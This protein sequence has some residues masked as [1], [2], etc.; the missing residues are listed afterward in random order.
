MN[1]TCVCTFHICFGKC[2]QKLKNLQLTF[3]TDKQSLKVKGYRAAG[4][5]NFDGT[6][7]VVNCAS[8]SGILNADSKKCVKTCPT[9][10]FINVAGNKCVRSCASSNFIRLYDSRCVTACGANEATVGKKCT[11]NNILSSNGRGS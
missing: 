9:D 11:C 4:V 7:C 10:Q 6:Q 8:I 3:C 2:K 1:Q 5:L